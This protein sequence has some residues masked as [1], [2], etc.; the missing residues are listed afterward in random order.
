[1]IIEKKYQT[2]NGER[3]DMSLFGAFPNCGVITFRLEFSNEK[4]IL[5]V[6]LAIHSDGLNSPYGERAKEY[7]MKTSDIVYPFSFEIDIPASELS[8]LTS[9]GLLYYRYDVVSENASFSLGG[10]EVSELYGHEEFGD[11]QLLL[12]DK[13]FRTPSFIKGGEIYHI[14]VDRFATSGKFPLKDGA[15]KNNDWEN[16][17]PEYAPYRGA[18]I[19]NNEFFGGDLAGAEEKIPYLASLGVTTVYLSPVFD[20]PSN[21]KYDTSDYMKVDPMFGG[22]KALESFVKKCRKFCPISRHS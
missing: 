11:R 2:I 5:S 10:E 15:K 6:K 4:R 13:D 17:V 14:F 20:S 18:P 9:N 19:Q 7:E 1:M 8:A 16:G 21:H 3:H 22:D 12:Y